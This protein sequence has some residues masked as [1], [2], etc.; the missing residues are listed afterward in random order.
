MSHNS[1]IKDISLAPEGEQ[2]IA[3][4]AQHAPVLNRLQGKYLKDG[5]FK[6]LKV[7]VVIHLEAKTAYLALLLQEA[8]AQ[9]TV[10]GSNPMSTQDAVA[11]ALVMR[12]VRVHAVHGCDQ[13]A[14]HE[15]LLRTLDTI[16]DLILDDGAE[17]VS[18]LYQHRPDLVS[19]VK[20]A[21]EET[22]SGILKLKAMEAEGLLAFPVIAA[23]NARCKHLF[24]NRY[25]TGQSVLGAVMSVTNLLIAGKAVVVAGYGWVGRGVARYLAGAGAHVIVCE[26]DAVKALEA[27]VDGYTVLPMAAAAR[28]G[29]L[30][31]T[32]TGSIHVL[33]SEH[34]A[35]MKDGALLANAGHYAH[36]IDVA[37][38][39]AMAKRVREARWKITEYELG[40]GRR[41][42]L[43][44]GGELANIAAAD[45]HPVEIMDLSFSVQALAAYHLAKY[46]GRLPIGVQPLPNHIDDEIAQAKLESAGIGF[47]TM[48]PEQEQYL[49]S[50]K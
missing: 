3:W 29:D 9:V 4:V 45:G 44:A 21:S 38:L 7:A 12:G 36:E 43:I 35:V 37:A 39:T 33:R 18:R 14:F 48:T 32:T 30:F 31:V 34:F 11:A 16:P 8:G 20:G 1:I 23:N 10:S 6:G 17:L 28:R 2:K 42:H 19:H 47:D 49:K 26:T 46:Q 27:V 25:G 5:T 50:W 15:H 13:A 24:D 22:T 41:I 40:D